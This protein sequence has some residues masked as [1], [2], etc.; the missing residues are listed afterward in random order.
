M[1]ITNYVSY[2]QYLLVTNGNTNDKEY[3]SAQDIIRT[4]L[5]FVGIC[6]CG[7]RPYCMATNFFDRYTDSQR[8]T[9]EYDK[10]KCKLNFA[11]VC[12]EQS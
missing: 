5:Y 12:L 10:T 3:S 2:A 11:L 6:N 4:T 8:N 9:S 7:L 1:I